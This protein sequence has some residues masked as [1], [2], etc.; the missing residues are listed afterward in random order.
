[1][2]EASARRLGLAPR[3]RF[4]SFALAGVDPRLMLTGHIPATR[5]LL[6]RARLSLDDI[7]LFEVGEAFASTVLAWERELDA[8][9]AKVN[10]NGGAIALGHPS[11]ASGARGLATLISELVRTGGRWALQ[12]MPEAGGLAN[13]TVIERMG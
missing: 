9:P 2:S 8:D 3:A 5:K 1:M 11:G 12:T 6:D 10:V 4:H 13:A 7:D